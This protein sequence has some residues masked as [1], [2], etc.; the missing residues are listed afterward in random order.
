[1]SPRRARPR[2]ARDSRVR[3]TPARR[4]GVRGGG[5]V[6]VRARGGGRGAARGAAGDGERDGD[7]ARGGRK[8]EGVPGRVGG[9]FRRRLRSGCVNARRLRLRRA[10]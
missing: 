3:H 10:P 9:V 2:R 7:V 4:R 8:R 6:R 5:R 1:M